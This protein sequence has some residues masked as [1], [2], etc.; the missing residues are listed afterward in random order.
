M[1]VVHRSGEPLLAHPGGGRAWWC[2]TAARC[3]F[4]DSSW[5]HGEDRK[6]AAE[7]A[8]G[9]ILDKGYAD[10]YQERNEP[11]H[12]VGVALSAKEGNLAAVKVVST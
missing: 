11:T 10:K 12:L 6:D 9:Q 2:S 3:L 8:I 7:Q 1:L 4:S 5:P